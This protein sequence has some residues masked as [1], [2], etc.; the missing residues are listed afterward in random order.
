MCNDLNYSEVIDLFRIF[1][2]E[3]KENMDNGEKPRYERGTES[4]PIE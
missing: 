3:D 2:E 4:I 1:N